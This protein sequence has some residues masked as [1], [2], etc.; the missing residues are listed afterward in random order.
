V[1]VQPDESILDLRG[2]RRQDVVTAPTD[3]LSDATIHIFIEVEP[4]S[5]TLRE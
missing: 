5:A 4:A 2:D 1:H 3:A